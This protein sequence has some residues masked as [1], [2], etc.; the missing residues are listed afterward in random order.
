MVNSRY[1]NGSELI[2]QDISNAIHVFDIRGS[3]SGSGNSNDKG[4][5]SLLNIVSK[6]N[7]T[8]SKIIQ[9]RFWISPD[10]KILATVHY[11]APHPVTR[12]YGFVGQSGTST[13]TPSTGKLA[14]I[15]YYSLSGVDEGWLG[16]QEIIH[17]YEE[18][19]ERSIPPVVPQSSLLFARQVGLRNY[20]QNECN[21]PIVL[22]SMK[23]QPNS[24]WSRCFV[25]WS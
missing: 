24:A 25:E 17:K 4:G 18:N 6:G 7:P 21:S 8:S 11:G 22:H 10:E 15:G 2:V 16:G 1:G 9:S 13:N 12:D 20:S 19:T 5:N 14:S 3:G 23:M